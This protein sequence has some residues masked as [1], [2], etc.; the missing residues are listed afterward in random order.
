[1]RKIIVLLS[2]VLIVLSTLSLVVASTN[3][4]KP[5]TSISPD[6]TEHESHDQVDKQTNDNGQHN[7]RDNGQH[8]D[9]DDGNRENKGTPIWRASFSFTCLD[10]TFCLGPHGLG[11]VGSLR[12]HAVFF[13][14]GTAFARVM[15]RTQSND[16]VVTSVEVDNVTNWKIASGV[17][18]A[19]KIGNDTFWF[20]SGTNTTHVRGGET[21][22]KAISN[23]NTM[24]PATPFTADTQQIFG[25]P[26][27]DKVSAHVEVSM[28]DHEFETPLT[29][30]SQVPPVTTDASGNVQVQIIDGGMA[31]RFE[32]TVC[33][34]QNVTQ[35]HIHVGAAGTN[36]VG[37]NIILWLYGP[38]AAKF[39][40]TGCSELAEGIL[41]PKDLHPNSANGVNTWS[42]F[43]TALTSGHTYV[44]VH[45]T[46][47]PMGE[48]RGQ[49]VL[50]SED[51]DN[52]D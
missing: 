30:A 41:T 50:N 37:N 29:G 18:I 5:S 7:D 49:L 24:V 31:V 22:V 44:N 32:L 1:M 3:I 28:V 34:I 20:V 6:T 27:S 33:D 11:A 9:H 43:L 45:T 39:S 46:A 15:I 26:T 36:G 21:T 10:T 42:D 4:H 8:N 16:K 40:T 35:A 2:A 19:P 23:F 12:G 13:A 51:E 25:V 52:S 38:N 14:E 47:H 17:S 48:I